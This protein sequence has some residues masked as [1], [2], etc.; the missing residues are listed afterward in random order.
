MRLLSFMVA[1]GAEEEMPARIQ[2]SQRASGYECILP[3]GLHVP[4]HYCERS[5]NQRRQLK[6]CRRSG[7]LLGQPATP[8][9][10]C[11]AI[12]NPLA[13]PRSHD[14]MSSHSAQ[15]YY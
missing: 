12:L 15:R 11:M 14:I 10:A 8:R 5:A 7:S 4:V 1:T 2:L 9:R 6:H 13:V 3:L